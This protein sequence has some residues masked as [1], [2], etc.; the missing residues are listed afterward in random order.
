[1]PSRRLE[2]RIRELCSKALVADETQIDLT[3]EELRL[4]LH[5]HAERLRKLAARKLLPLNPAA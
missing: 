4:A 1:M 3:L 5:E 2:D